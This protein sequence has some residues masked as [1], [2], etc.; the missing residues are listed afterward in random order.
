MFKNLSKI[1]DPDPVADYIRNLS[2][3]SLPKD[4]YLVQFS[5]RF[6]Q[7]DVFVREI[8]RR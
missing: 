8:A 2:I 4:I 6:G 3:S 1:V 5:C 7:W